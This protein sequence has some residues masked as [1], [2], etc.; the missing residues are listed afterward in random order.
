MIAK[1]VGVC[2]GAIIEGINLSK[3]LREEEI[4]YI[5]EAWLKYHVICFPEQKLT[6]DQLLRFSRYF[7]QFGE[8]PFIAPIQGRKNILA[9]QRRA[10]EKT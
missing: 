7:G 6:M 1:Q 9:I 8:D 2:H 5:R 10:T 3:P 4:T